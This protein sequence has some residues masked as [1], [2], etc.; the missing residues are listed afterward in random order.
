MG[1]APVVQYST[2]INRNTVENLDTVLLTNPEVPLL[3]TE[4]IV[5]GV[6][7]LGFLY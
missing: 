7:G 2:F 3:N 1:L 4:M 6:L 5:V